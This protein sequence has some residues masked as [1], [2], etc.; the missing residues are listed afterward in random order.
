MDWDCVAFAQALAAGQATL[1]MTVP[2]PPAT[3]PKWLIDLMRY[4]RSGPLLLAP[5]PLVAGVRALKQT[6][7]PKQTSAPAPLIRGTRMLKQ[8]YHPV[9]MN[10]PAR[11]IIAARVLGVN[12]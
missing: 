4:V 1:G 6:Y 9:T 10:A 7:H 8:T 2:S 5:A 11:P 12:P 3:Y